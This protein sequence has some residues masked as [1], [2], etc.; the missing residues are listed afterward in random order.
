M[1][2]GKASSWKN[3]RAGVPKDPVLGCLLFLTY[4]NDLVNG[5]ESICKI[6]TDDIL[7]FLKVKNKNFSAIQ[8]NSNL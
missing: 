8:L 5:I 3:I 4:I 1:L 6:F 2:N 7:L